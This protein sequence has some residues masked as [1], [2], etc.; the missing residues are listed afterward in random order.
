M[1]LRYLSIYLNDHL[2]GATAGV[3]LA[4]RTARSNI[5]TSYG[6][7]LERLRADIERD[8][9][10]LVEIMTRLGVSRSPVKG[11]LAWSAEKIG[12]LKLNGRI[13]G[14]SPLSRVVEV[15]G[16]SIGV[17]GKIHLW[18]SLR[19]LAA[20]DERLEAGMLDELLA[21]GRDQ[22]GR[23]DDLRRRAVHEALVESAE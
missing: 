23:L 7:E 13:R 10:S 17:R 16:L 9:A 15:E 19:E 14:Y 21:R 12:R 20:R 5:G 11:P 3:E 1:D 6:G 18:T 2:A 22:A 8:R 4:K